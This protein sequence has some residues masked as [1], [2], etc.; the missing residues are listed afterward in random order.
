MAQKRGNAGLTAKTV[1]REQGIGNREQV[2]TDLG[3]GSRGCLKPK[4]RSVNRQRRHPAAPATFEPSTQWQI[5]I[6]PF[7]ES[8]YLGTPRRESLLTCSAEA[9]AA[10]ATETAALHFGLATLGWFTPLSLYLR[11]WDSIW[12]ESEMLSLEPGERRQ[13]RRHYGNQI[14][15]ALLNSPGQRMPM[16]GP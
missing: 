14:V 12:F 1:R 13:C 4:L 2:G 9:R 8:R 5:E 6:G 7:L 11:I 3:R 10:I 15:L 16:C